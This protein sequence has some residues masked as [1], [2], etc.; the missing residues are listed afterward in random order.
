MLKYVT[1]VLFE[2]K[3]RCFG[4]L[5]GR[6]C[7][8]VEL[9]HHDWEYRLAEYSQLPGGGWAVRRELTLP[10]STERLFLTMRLP[11]WHKG[12]SIGR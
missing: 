11:K 1:E 5:F 10:A 6:R 7:A 8:D 4:W 12:P 3:M 2:G 9:E